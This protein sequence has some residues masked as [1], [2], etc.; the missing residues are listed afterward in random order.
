MVR[1]VT[2]TVL[3]S[4]AVP[5]AARADHA[6]P[7][8]S[9]ERAEAPPTPY[10]LATAGRSWRIETR[11]GPVHVW[12]PDGYDARTAAIVVYVHGYFVDVDEAW[13]DQRLPEQFAMS[14]ANAMFVACGAPEG[15]RGRVAWPSL[16]HLLS[17]VR[18]GIDR[19]L[20]KGRLVA[21]GH[22][23]AHRTIAQWLDNRRLD[24]IVLV[25]AAYGDLRPFRHWLR[26][27][28]DHRLLDVGAL[29]QP[30]TDAFH[31]HVP[32]LVVEGFPDPD[33]AHDALEAWR[34]A[35]VIYVRSHRDH[36]QLVTEGLALP[37]LL[38]ALRA[39]FVFEPATN[40]IAPFDDDDQDS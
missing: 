9:E 15:P 33:V 39:P 38:R 23:G 27:S 16:R 18:R 2:L 10:E 11:R 7:P 14:G 40:P 6:E 21:V 24:A 31:R 17:V 19:P 25:D 8:T 13:R 12:V 35:R 37:M 28:K 32:S 34:K 4:L 22:S 5:A 20:P 29:T 30:K 36:M 26:A 1:L 3:A